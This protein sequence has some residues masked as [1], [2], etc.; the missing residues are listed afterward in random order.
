MNIS[1]F[2]RGCTTTFW[3]DNSVLMLADALRNQA[4]HFRQSLYVHGVS[5]PKKILFLTVRD[6]EQ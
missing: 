4:H 6:D 2:F 3:G 1:P 5:A